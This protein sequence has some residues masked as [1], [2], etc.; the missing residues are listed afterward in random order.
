LNEA[1]PNKLQ[2]NRTTGKK[3][4]MSQSKTGVETV[5]KHGRDAIINKSKNVIIEID[6]DIK[7]GI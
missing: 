7:E 3:P 5:A 2:Q 4:S 6:T 1:F